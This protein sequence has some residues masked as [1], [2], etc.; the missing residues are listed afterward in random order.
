[1][2]GLWMW[3]ARGGY[4]MVALS[5]LALLLAFL[6]LERFLTTGAQMRAIASGRESRFP[7]EIPGLRRMGMIRAFI[8]VAPLIGLLGTVTG[9]IETFHGL[10]HGGHIPE[11]SKGIFKALLTTQYGLAIAAPGL[12]A[13]RILLRRVEKFQC[14]LRGAALAGREVPKC[15][16]ES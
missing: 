9:M 11:L 13:E 2:S 7:V 4:T 8:V 12:V 10:L 6:I 15:T 16:G 1:M 5:V 3:F 14:F